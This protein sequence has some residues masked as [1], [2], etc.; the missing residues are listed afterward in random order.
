MTV[1]ELREALA[2]LDPDLDVY[3]DLTKEGSVM[4]NLALLLTVEPVEIENTEIS[5]SEST[6]IMLTPY[7]SPLTNDP[8]SMN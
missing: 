2:E 4:W 6:V 3:L 1:Q 5:E 7:K 8:P